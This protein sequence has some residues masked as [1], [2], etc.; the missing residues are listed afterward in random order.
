M[1]RVG[2]L[3][4][5]TITDDRVLGESVIQRSLRFNRSSH[6]LSRALGSPTSDDKASVSVW[7][8]RIAVGTDNSFFDN[9]QGTNDRLTI[10]LV[11][12]TDGDALGVYQR[13]SSGI[14]C[15]LLTTQKFRD[16]SAWYHLL[17]AFDT[18]QGTEAD[19]VKMYVNGTQVTSFS[20][21][22][23]FSQNHNLRAGSGYTTNIGRYGAGSNYFGGYLAEVNY[24]DGQ[25]LSPTDV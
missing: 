24:I 12:S 14:V 17:V 13:D 22:T 15:N 2:G 8:K 5:P 9:Y 20:S 23:Y 18:T 19:R 16:P 4:L 7:L 11:S 6:Y 25:Q 21:S 3:P 1:A 10:S